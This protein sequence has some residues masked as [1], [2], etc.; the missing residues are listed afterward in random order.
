MKWESPSW[1]DIRMDAEIGSYQS[2]F[3]GEDARGLADPDASV[4]LPEMDGD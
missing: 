3:V 1:I 4:A 2:D